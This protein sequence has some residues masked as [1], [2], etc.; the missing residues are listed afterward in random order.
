MRQKCFLVFDKLLLLEEK[1][2]F[3]RDISFRPPVLSVA[4]HEPLITESRWN[5]RRE[6]VCSTGRECQNRMEENARWRFQRWIRH[7][8]G[9]RDEKSLPEGNVNT[10]DYR[11]PLQ[12]MYQTTCVPSAEYEVRRTDAVCYECTCDGFNGSSVGGKNDGR[13]RAGQKLYGWIP[14]AA[15]WGNRVDRKEKRPA[16]TICST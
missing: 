15:N 5:R 8:V 7:A 4:H 16:W 14:E 9:G 2:Q 10:G 6:T 12:V 11:G 3:T 13:R 1:K